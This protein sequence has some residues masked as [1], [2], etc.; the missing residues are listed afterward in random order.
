MSFTVLGRLQLNSPLWHI[1]GR[2][3]ILL[4]LGRCV[5]CGIEYDTESECDFH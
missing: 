5:N 2:I 3:K 1:Y 4:Q